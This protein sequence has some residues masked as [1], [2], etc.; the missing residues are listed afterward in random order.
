MRVVWYYLGQRSIGKTLPMV[1]LEQDRLHWYAFFRGTAVK[2][3]DA[4]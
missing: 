1:K 3:D 4:R 2:T